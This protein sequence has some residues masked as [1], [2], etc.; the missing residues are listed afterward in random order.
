MYW[1]ELETNEEALSVVMMLVGLLRCHRIM[2]FVCLAA[3]ACCSQRT[4][5]TTIFGA[6]ELPSAF[7]WMTMTMRI[8]SAC[9]SA[10]SAAS[11]SGDAGNDEI[12]LCPTL[13]DIDA[14]VFVS[15]S[16]SR[17]HARDITGSVSCSGEPGTLAWS[18]SA[19]ST[20]FTL[21]RS[22]SMPFLFDPSDCVERFLLRYAAVLGNTS[23][24]E[25]TSTTDQNGNR[26]LLWSL[27]DTVV[28]NETSVAYDGDAKKAEPP[29]SGAYCGVLDSNS[30]N[31]AG[32]G[33]PLRIDFTGA[34]NRAVRFFSPGSSATSAVCQL[35]PVWWDAPAREL[36]LS[37][38][39]ASTIHRQSLNVN[40]SPAPI[41]KGTLLP[42]WPSCVADALGF[43]GHGQPSKVWA[44]MPTP[45][46]IVLLRKINESVSMTQLRSCAGSPTPLLFRLPSWL[47]NGSAYPAAGPIS[48]CGSYGAVPS[49]VVT[50]MERVVTSSLCG[51]S[52]REECEAVWKGVVAVSSNE[53][54]STCEGV[55]FGL[56]P[57]TGRDRLVTLVNSSVSS[58]CA[59]AA[60]GTVGRS[61][62]MLLRYD[63]SNDMFWMALSVGAFA[64]TPC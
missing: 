45:N 13:V 38:P 48:Y 33:R 2:L 8:R 11:S 25:V 41:E 42:W 32:S 64:L 5:S 21:E 40:F 62:F 1:K 43:R 12:M 57:L 55:L 35:L 18:R 59:K 29:G 46:Q 56:S 27:G 53:F 47:Q 22:V 37:T 14:A 10:C 3:V 31:S 34:V 44:Y 7:G 19:A 26:T 63:M 58:A 15:H 6:A 9:L 28:F 61:L 39:F 4:P 17:V 51:S 24:M 49:V 50:I 23:R 52:G 20:S 16:V 30:S 54:T 36:I 60:F